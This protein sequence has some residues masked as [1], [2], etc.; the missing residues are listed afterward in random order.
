[1]S[2]GGQVVAVVNVESAWASKVNWTAAIGGLAA[3]V[4]AVAG[5]KYNMTPEQ[6]GGIVGGIA[7]FQS[8]VVV[9]LK[10]FFT[11]TV[12]P[13]S[14]ASTPQNVLPVMTTIAPSP[15]DGTTAIIPPLILTPM[16]KP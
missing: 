12:T 4:A 13:S 2:V 3:F 9:V 1:M 11:T 14:V 6:I 15:I 8:M 16:V 5:A 7:M 10:T